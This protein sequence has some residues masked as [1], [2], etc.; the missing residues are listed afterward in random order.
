MAI[1]SRFLP[2]SRNDQSGSFIPHR[3]WA[4]QLF[5]MLANLFFGG[6]LSDSING[7]RA[8]NKNK[9]KTLNVDADGFAI[10]YQ[11][12]IRAM[13]LKQK[14]KEIPT[15]EGNRI[16]RKSGAKSIPVGLNILKVLIREIFS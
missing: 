7:F 6:N 8:V 15:I 12:S 4:N 5:K 3:A 9:F 10:E 16:G 14:I 11:S 13:K 2:G 1:A